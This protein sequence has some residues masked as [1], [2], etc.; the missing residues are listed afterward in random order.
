MFNV[1]PLH[2]AVVGGGDKLVLVSLL[3]RRANV[4][5]EDCYKLDISDN[6]ILS[7]LIISVL[8][9]LHYIMQRVTRTNMKL[10]GF[11]YNTEQ[12]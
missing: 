7:L 3:E 10:V 1:H 4:N 2:R 8:G 9:T 6:V 12:W 11:Y 5:A